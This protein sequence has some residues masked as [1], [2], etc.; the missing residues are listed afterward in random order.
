MRAPSAMSCE[1]TV[2]CR[3]ESDVIVLRGPESEASS[4]ILRGVLVLCLAQPLKVE[5]VHLRLTGQCRVGY[6][7]QQPS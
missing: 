3:L 2:N 6:V 4:Q 5:D 7:S 1:L